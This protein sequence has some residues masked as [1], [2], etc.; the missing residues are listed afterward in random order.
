MNYQECQSMKQKVL[1][2]VLSNAEEWKKFLSCAAKFY[3]Y[4]FPNQL[5]IYGQNPAAKACA[6]SGEWNRVARKVQKN[7]KPITLYN[8]N[9]KH[10]TEQTYCAYDVSQTE[11]VQNDRFRI[12]K[13]N[14]AEIAQFAD[15]LRKE[16]PALSIG[17]RRSTDESFILDVIEEQVTQ[18]NQKQVS[19]AWTATIVG[20]VQYVCLKRMGIE[21]ETVMLTSKVVP[22]PP[23]ELEQAAHVCTYA[24]AEAALFLRKTE[25]MVK[26]LESQ[27]N[28]EYAMSSKDIDLN[29]K[30]GR[31][32]KY[33]GPRTKTMGK[34]MARS[35][36]RTLNTESGHT[37]HLFAG[38]TVESSGHMGF[39][40]GGR[41]GN[42]G[43]L[44]QTRTGSNGTDRDGR[45]RNVRVGAEEFSETVQ[46]G[47]I[48]ENAGRFVTAAVS[49]G[50]ERRGG[51]QRGTSGVPDGNG[52][53]RDRRPENAGSDEVGRDG[54]QHHQ[55]SAGNRE[56]RTDLR[57][58]SFES[59]VLTNNEKIALKENSEPVPIIYTKAKSNQLPFAFPYAQKENNIPES[60]PVEKQAEKNDAKTYYHF[61]FKNHYLFTVS[62]AKTAM[63]VLD[64]LCIFSN[65]ESGGNAW[66]DGGTIVE[67]KSTVAPVSNLWNADKEKTAYIPYSQKALESH[68]S[69]LSNYYAGRVDEQSLWAATAEVDTEQLS[70]FNTSQP[71]PVPT[72]KSTQAKGRK[73]E[74]I[75]VEKRNYVL[76]AVDDDVS[77]AKTKYKGNVA[78]IRMLKA[79]QTE[80]RTATPEEQHILARYSGWGGAADAF[81]ATKSTWSNEYVELKE[82]LTKEEYTAARSST[83]NAHYTSPEIIRAI[84][85][86]IEHIGIKPNSIL[87]PACGTG[88]FFGCLPESMQ[89]CKLHGIELD[90]ITGQIARQLY[91]KAN[92]EI[93]GFEE[94]S[95]PD[96]S[97]DLA[98]GNVPFGDY[99]VADSTFKEKGLLIHDYFFAKALQKIRPG[100]IVAF[101]TSSGTMDKKN[102]T[103]R[104]YINQRA[105]F[106][107]A[108]R[109]PNNAFSAA[110]TEVTS[111]IL[112]LQKRKSVNEGRDRHAWADPADGV[113]IGFLDGVSVNRYFAENPQMVLG[114]MKMVSG[115]Y[116]MTATCE[117]NG[118]L[119]EQL[120]AA[121]QQLDVLNTGR[122]IPSNESYGIVEQ[123]ATYEEPA[124]VEK[125]M[126]GFNNLRLFSYAAD[127][128]KLYFKEASGMVPVECSDTVRRK[129][130]GMAEIRDIMWM[131]YTILKTCITL[132]KCR[133]WQE[134]RRRMHRNLLT[135]L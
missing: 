135:C 50:N 69:W 123:S 17:R 37:E 66:T 133:M 11:A 107:G 39:G 53:G 110:G 20:A 14:R 32:E 31:N 127:G 5:L 34:E 81:D 85:N 128:K 102:N 46:A 18:H 116:G 55:F 44:L 62:N 29:Y 8:T 118:T 70:F 132:Q 89:D 10:G 2:R 19:A 47:G 59:E 26:S 9:A 52:A 16:H 68:E 131:K 93:K 23:M 3:K 78:A 109:L 94:S 130:T 7:V 97:F 88:R 90:R 87:E 108:V 64:S 63:K 114:E 71:E 41:T 86:G 58:N 72:G 60:V 25:K 111:D 38:G 104:K 45:T 99:E 42:E 51:E 35:A 83:L 124:D 49:G 61:Y 117:A 48:S 28:I 98:V 77:G 57:V 120:A 65:N 67:S 6:A 15:K 100:G 105:R 82:L 112:F 30:S 95:V 84:Y 74:L 80:N 21:P 1:K 121:M 126:A 119:S 92:I 43:T 79:I 75:P 91:P 101:I 33:E 96:N 40:R 125:P 106:L 13:A 12:W 76:T 122:E 129:I 4:S 73:S 103:V 115:P 113:Q 27:P 22:P 54:E 134:F 36:G 56:E 24:A